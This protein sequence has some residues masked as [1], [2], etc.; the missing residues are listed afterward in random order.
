MYLARST[1][2]LIALMLVL[3]F[4]EAR[5]ASLSLRSA[6]IKDQVK[7]LLS[8]TGMENEYARFLSFLK[9]YPPKD[10][11]K[12][13]AFYDD[14]FSNNA[15]LSDLIRTYSKYYTLDEINQLINFYSSPVGKKSVQAV[16]DLYRQ[17]ED[18]MLTKI[19]DYIFTAAENGF[20]VPLT[21]FL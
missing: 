7:H 4:T 3:V 19:S 21:D 5:Q 13:K 16:N 1:Q 10:N 2:F 9:I 14:M 15:Y 8:L 6:N 18:I 20:E 11:A 17:M 12:M